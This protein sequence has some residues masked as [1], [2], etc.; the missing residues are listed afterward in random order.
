MKQKG[1]Q[2]V[3]EETV[4]SVDTVKEL[5]AEAWAETGHDRWKM[6]VSNIDAKG[7]MQLDWVMDGRKVTLCLT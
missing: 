6:P 7:R 5:V 1:F 3:T 4:F 2:N